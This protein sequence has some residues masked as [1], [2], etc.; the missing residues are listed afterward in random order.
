MQQDKLSRNV[1]C[2]LSPT[3]AAAT[4]SMANIVNLSDLETF[5]FSD[6][7]P[8]FRTITGLLLFQPACKL[9]LTY[10]YAIYSELRGQGAI[11]PTFLGK[12]FRINKQLCIIFCSIYGRFWLLCGTLQCILLP[13]AIFSRKGNIGCQFCLLDD[14]LHGRF[15][16]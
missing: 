14:F 9:D 2:T 11:F 4:S 5:S 7:R 1:L 16:R 15:N 8:Q 13:L 12:I 3:F 10:I 6:R